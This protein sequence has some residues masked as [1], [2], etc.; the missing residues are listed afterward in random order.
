MPTWK[1]GWLN[2]NDDPLAYSSVTLGKLFNHF[3]LSF[4]EYKMKV[5]IVLNL[6]GYG[7]DCMR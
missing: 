4:P 1:S 3:H 2:L 7:E 6:Q 5:V